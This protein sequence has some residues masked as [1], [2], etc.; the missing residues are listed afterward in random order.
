[1]KPT[2]NIDI[3]KLKSCGGIEAEFAQD[4][5]SYI[6]KAKAFFNFCE[7]KD[8]ITRCFCIR[9]KGIATQGNL[10][11]HTGRFNGFG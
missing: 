7:S 10:N 5:T 1:M 3:S 11:L 6:G 8:T 9:R 4:G 2:K